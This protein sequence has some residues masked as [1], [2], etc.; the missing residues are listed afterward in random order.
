MRLH[1][2]P[3]SIKFK[4][5]FSVSQNSRSHTPVV[6]TS[7]EHEGVTGF[8]EASA[9]PYLGE[10]TESML[11]FL[12]KVDLGRFSSPFD[13]EDILAYI[14][15]IEDGNNAAKASIDIALHDLVGKLNGQPLYEMFHTSRNETPYTSFTIGISDIN[16]IAKKVAE[17][18]PFKYLKL[19]LGSANDKK[20]IE[21]VRSITSK[22]IYADI[23]QGWSDKSQVLDMICWLKENGVV[24]IEQPM[25]KTMVDELAWLTEHSPLPIVA[26]ESVRR[27]ADLEKYYSAFSGVNIKL[28]K[29]T[30]LCEA[31][32]MIAFARRK[33]LKVMIG[34]MSETSCA[35]TA[36]AH[37]SPLA[38]YADL[39]GPLLITNDI[40]KGIEYADGKIALPTQPG[41]G[42]QPLHNTELEPLLFDHTL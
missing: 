30:G 1:Y 15:R 35:T 32:K 33:G 18:E 21:Q 31:Q 42:I 17:A 14:D 2:A 13:I 12:S 26:D 38:D 40:F 24:L 8:G 6:I 23:N 3:F 11:A 9:P 39:D 28:M 5:V 37:L 22:P 27:L 34:C 16:D 4:H 20:I 25:P 10:N 41:I 7:I 36:A 29:C 19:K